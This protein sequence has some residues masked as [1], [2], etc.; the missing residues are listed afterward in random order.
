ME[1]SLKST[2]LF[3]AILLTGLSAGLFY[4]WEVS[5]IPGTRRIP[6]KSYLETMQAINRA[7]LNPAFFVVFVGSLI[8][9]G[10]N[11]FLEFRSGWSLAFFFMIGA[12]LTYGMGTFG[13]TAFGNV[14][15]NEALDVVK[16]VDL[17]TEG[18]HETRISY[19][20]KWNYWHKLRT[21]CSVISF[22]LSLL[23]LF[24]YSSKYNSLI[25]NS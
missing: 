25:T 23:S 5:V 20:S 17:T 11:T 6:D 4:A 24:L 2:S 9:L 18:M 10:V 13:I 1:L 21:I 3:I 22:I 7:I 14:P 15:L 19:E 12:T 8:A 16:L